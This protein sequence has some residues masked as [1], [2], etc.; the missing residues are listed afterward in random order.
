MR[1]MLAFDPSFDVRVAGRFPDRGGINHHVALHG[2]RATR[3]LDILDEV[4]EGRWVLPVLSHLVQSEDRHL[5]AK[6]T[7]FVGRRVQSAQWAAKRTLHSYRTDRFPTL[8]N[9]DRSADK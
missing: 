8:N 1:R 7:L 6:V 5:S 2:R 4:S 3:V 9:S